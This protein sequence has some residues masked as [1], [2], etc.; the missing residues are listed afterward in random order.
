M[1]L[2]R[3]RRL[4]YAAT[5]L[6]VGGFVALVVSSARQAS[7]PVGT[8]MPG[9]RMGSARGAALSLELRDVGGRRLSLPGGRPGAIVFVQARGCSPCLATVRAAAAAIRAGGRPTALTVVAADSTTSRS[10][11]AGFARSAGN[12]PASY[13]IDDRS[14]SVAMMAGATSLGRAVV[15]D[16]RGRAL[17]S[18]G[19]DTVALALRRA[20]G[21]RARGGSARLRSQLRA[22]RARWS[23][24]HAGSYSYRLRRRCFCP[25]R[26]PVTIRV[27]NR[28]PVAP[29]R[30]F[31]AFDT[32]GKLFGY[33]AAEIRRPAASLTV[34]Y[35][36]RTGVPTDITVDPI[37]DAIDDEQA[38]HLRR[39]RITQRYLERG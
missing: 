8:S 36:A 3:D 26:G 27:R 23:A 34:R 5:L 21:V 29:P 37:A 9:M 35:D 22:A 6:V 10:D 7:V 16:A 18:A 1:S 13:V 15:Y 30:Y 38:L 31:E 17:A 11:L 2:L 32:V 28:R 25:A 12:P 20:A 33:V 14:G 19:A 24:Q 4:K 39:L